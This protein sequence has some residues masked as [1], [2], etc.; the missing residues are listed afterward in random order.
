MNA[1]SAMPEPEPP[2]LLLASNSQKGLIRHGSVES[3]KLESS[4]KT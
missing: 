1:Q 2:S 3:E 4:K